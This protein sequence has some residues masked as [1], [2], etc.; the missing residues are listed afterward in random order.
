MEQRYFFE[1]TYMAMVKNAFK[2]MEKSM[3]KY[4]VICCLALFFAI[5]FLAAAQQ[6]E[7][8]VKWTTSVKQ[9]APNEYDLVFTAI[10]NNGWHVYS[11]FI[12]EGG[13]VP[14][15]FNFNEGKYKREGKVEEKGHPE[16]VFDQGFEMNLVYFSGKPEFVQH[17]KLT[18]PAKEI[19]GYFEYMVCNDEM[20][21]PPR[22]IEFSFPVQYQPGTK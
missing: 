12:E 4:L 13:P 18:G 5:P 20:C 7:E 14:T 1:F 2:L 9:T 21:L 17:V 16:K 10:L 3:R 6:E 22:K 11:Q 8:P 19:T 15:N